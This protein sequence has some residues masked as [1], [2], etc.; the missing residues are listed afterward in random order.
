MMLDPRALLPGLAFTEKQQSLTR[1][2]KITGPAS[3]LIELRYEV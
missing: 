2:G 3:F 1:S